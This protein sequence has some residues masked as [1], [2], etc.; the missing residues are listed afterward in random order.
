MFEVYSLL[1]RTASLLFFGR[2][3]LQSE[4]CLAGQLACIDLW[5]SGF[6]CLLHFG[7]VYYGHISVQT[8]LE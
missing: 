2:V 8:I 7:F 4:V 6:L 1:F 5:Q 3:V